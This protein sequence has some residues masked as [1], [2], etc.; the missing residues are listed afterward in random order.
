MLTFSDLTLSQKKC[1][2][3][4]IDHSSTAIP[5]GTISLK[6]IQRI[7]AELA[8]NRCDGAP[9]IGY[10]NWLFKANK[11]K[12]GLYKLPIPSAEEL[13][14]ARNELAIGKLPKVKVPKIKVIKEP[15]IKKELNQKKLTN[16]NNEEDIEEFNNILKENGIEV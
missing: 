3:A 6:E 16:L 2:I 4:I 15:K 13:E 8:A 12:P 5:L 7:C 11:L 9:I 1:I 10:P 14:K